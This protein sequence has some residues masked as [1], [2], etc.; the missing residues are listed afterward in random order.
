[1]H[2]TS[3]WALW[4]QRD[5]WLDGYQGFGAERG[6]CIKNTLKD[7][8]MGS[9]SQTDKPCQIIKKSVNA[10]WQNDWFCPLLT[11]KMGCFI[12]FIYFL[13]YLM[14]IYTH[15]LELKYMQKRNTLK[16]LAVCIQRNKNRP[17]IISKSAV[18]HYPFLR[19][20]QCSQNMF[21][22]HPFI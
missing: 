3:W 4:K 14:L 18:G 17:V 21:I 13:I 20:Y 7:N 12:L 1:M 11:S 19:R 6:D 10:V 22:G 16:T 9:W 2:S 8:V 15:K 5:S